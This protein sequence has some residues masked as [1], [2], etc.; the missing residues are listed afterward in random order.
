MKRQLFNVVLE[1]DRPTACEF[2]SR[3][4]VLSF[5]CFK[6]RSV[7]KKKLAYVISVYIPPIMKLGMYASLALVSVPQCAP[8]EGHFPPCLSD[9]PT[10]GSLP[11]PHA[12]IIPTNTLP[13]LKM[14]EICFFETWAS[15]AHNTTV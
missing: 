9:W 15:A 12:H 5:S 6:P 10:L 8:Q 13:T 11:G 2:R 1:R 14:E 3:Q 7:F 4:H